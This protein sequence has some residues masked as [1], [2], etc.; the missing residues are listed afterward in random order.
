MAF[1]EDIKNL[2]TNQIQNNESNLQQRA[3]PPG[4][5]LQ[6]STPSIPSPP[7]YGQ[8]S[9]SKP[10]KPNEYDFYLNAIKRMGFER[11]VFIKRD[12]FEMVA[13]S[14]KRLDSAEKWRH[15]IETQRMLNSRQ[16]LVVLQWFR[17]HFLT[18]N[19]SFEWSS[20]FAFPP[21]ILNIV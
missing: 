6:S 13:L 1:L 10:S 20:N 9:A 16:A 12:D 7:P 2:G 18:Q 5:Y 15:R 21:Y 11:I 8:P 3:P 4:H 19:S 14:D 17:K